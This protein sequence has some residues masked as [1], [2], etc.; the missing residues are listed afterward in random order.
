MARKTQIG[1]LGISD[2]NDFGVQIV[3]TMA[4]STPHFSQAEALSNP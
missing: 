3:P 2:I 4:P 1:P